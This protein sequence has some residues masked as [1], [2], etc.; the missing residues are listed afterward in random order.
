MPSKKERLDELVGMRILYAT[1]AEE[2]HWCG[3]RGSWIQLCRPPDSGALD[4][5]LRTHRTGHDLETDIRVP[6]Y[7][8]GMRLSAP[9][10]L[11]AWRARITGVVK[12]KYR[13][14]DPLA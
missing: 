4:A 9:G 3:G 14:G 5:R 6:G 10:L 7:R 8:S 13:H 1:P 11:S 2:E 12:I